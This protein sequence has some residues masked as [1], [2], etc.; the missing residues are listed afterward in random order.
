MQSLHPGST[1]EK[2]VHTNSVESGY[3]LAQLGVGRGGGS[4]RGSGRGTR[5][6]R[7]D[8]CSGLG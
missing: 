4:S 5:V 3:M 7:T 1:Q 8:S 6:W 2:V